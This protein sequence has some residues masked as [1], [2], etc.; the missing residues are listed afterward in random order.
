MDK[1]VKKLP[2]CK[3][4]GIQ[5]DC[6]NGTMEIVLFRKHLKGCFGTGFYLCP[7]HYEELKEYIANLEYERGKGVLIES[8]LLTQKSSEG[9]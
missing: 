7:E 1:D 2:K 5:G 3:I 4:C 8:S 9:K 6:S